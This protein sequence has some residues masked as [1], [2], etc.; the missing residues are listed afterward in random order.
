MSDSIEME[1]SK[2]FLQRQPIRY[3][4]KYAHKQ[5]RVEEVT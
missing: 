2:K 3:K 1:L 5:I 4:Q